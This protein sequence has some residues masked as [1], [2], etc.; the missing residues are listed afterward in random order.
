MHCFFTQKTPE[1]GQC[2]VNALSALFIDNR[3]F[4]GSQQ[5]IV[6]A[7]SYCVFMYGLLLYNS[8]LTYPRSA[9]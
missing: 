9:L 7:L 6:N 5:Y 3:S 2:I 8:A 1:S 4:W